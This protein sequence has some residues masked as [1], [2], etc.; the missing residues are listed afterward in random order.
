M[1]APVLQPPNFKLPFMVTTD[2]SLQTL[3]AVLSQEGK[4]ISFLSKT[5]SKQQENWTI[6]EKE[7]FT[8]IIA[9]RTW[10]YYLLSNHKVTIIMDNNVITSINSQKKISP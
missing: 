10:E 2:A 9:L 1:E 6:Y 7:M 5:F 8:I 3:G 4:P